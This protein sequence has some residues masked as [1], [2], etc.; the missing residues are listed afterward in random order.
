[1]VTNTSVLMGDIKTR[2]GLCCSCRALVEFTVSRDMGQV[3]CKVRKL[4]FKK[5][6]FQLFKEL[7]NKTLRETALRGKGEKKSWQNFRDAF[8]KVEEVFIFT[9]KKSR[10]ENRRLVW[11]NTNLS[12]TKRQEGNAHTAEMGTRIL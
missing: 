12:Q 5:A 1:M 8:Y 3:K 6:K 11:L 10:K 7:V 2:S 4:N 9:C